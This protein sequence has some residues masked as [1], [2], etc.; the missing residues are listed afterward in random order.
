MQLEDLLMK[1]CFIGVSYF[2]VQG[3]L[4]KQTQQAGQHEW[5]EWMPNA[6]RPQ[7]GRQVDR[8]SGRVA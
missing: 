4:M 8:N 1:T 2:D 5:W 6:E 7:V 3:E